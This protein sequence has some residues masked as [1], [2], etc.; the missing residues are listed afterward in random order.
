MFQ[1]IALDVPLGLGAIHAFSIRNTTIRNIETN[2]ET[3]HEKN[4][5]FMFL[6]LLK[7]A[8]ETF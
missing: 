6:Y 1:M 7:N 8:Q 2:F 5:H 3:S 4:V